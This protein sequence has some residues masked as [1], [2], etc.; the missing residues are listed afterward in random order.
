MMKYYT[1]G[2]SLSSDRDAATVTLVPAPARPDPGPRSYDQCQPCLSGSAQPVPR[3]ISPP[4]GYAYSS[5]V[6]FSRTHL[7][8]PD[9]PD[10]VA[11]AALPAGR[12]GTLDG[13][14]DTWLPL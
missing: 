6:T 8:R 5:R 9:P 12:T 4:P 10:L 3:G 1:P 11:E 2:S 13:L 7:R 14:P